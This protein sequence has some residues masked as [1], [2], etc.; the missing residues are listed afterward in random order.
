MMSA[1]DIQA[2]TRRETIAAAMGS[3]LIHLLVIVCIALTVALR[4]CLPLEEADPTPIE[5]TVIA[6]APPKPAEPTY[7]RTASQNLPDAPK[8]AAFE[9]D[10]NTRA[11]SEA[12]P[13][14]TRQMPSVD[15]RE[16]PALELESQR[17]S[18]GRESQPAQP[19][20]AAAEQAAE[21]APMPTPAA[22]LALREA[23]E[24]EKT[25]PPR[26]QEKA[27]APKP[28]AAAGFQPET[29]I[30]RIR[31]NISN[32][33]RASVEAAATPLG[34]YKKMVS[35]A[36]GSR[37]YYYVNSQ[38]GL[39]NIGTVDIRFQVGPEGKAQRVKILSNTSNESFASVSMRSILEAEIPPI[40]PDVAKLLDNGRL[41]IDYSFTILSN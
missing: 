17:Y 14:G 23:P 29:R 21:A 6:A 16:S 4:P 34:R 32:R 27:S 7:V 13:S 33:G 40:P 9:S 41:E 25:Q 20:P 18:G 22:Q 24:P 10:N 11:A 31:G 36:I 15:G 30:T 1:L 26:P 28:A 19:A 2:G 38:I 3:V 5:M 8:S 35:D 12:A 39:L 37:W